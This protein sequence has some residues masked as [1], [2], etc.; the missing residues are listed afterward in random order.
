MRVIVDMEDGEIVLTIGSERHR[1]LDAHFAW[2]GAMPVMQVTHPL[3]DVEPVRQQAPS[4]GYRTMD[5]PG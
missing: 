5:S 1:V 2:D 4:S 3:A